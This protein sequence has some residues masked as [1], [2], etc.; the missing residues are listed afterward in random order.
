M[1]ATK[2]ISAYIVDDEKD[3]RE[4]LSKMIEAYLPD[5]LKVIGTA[6]M[7]EKALKEIAEW[8]PQMLFL[9]IEIPRMTGLELAQNLHDKGYHGK[10]VF[11]TGHEEYMLKAIRTGA[12]DYLL[13]PVNPDEL[14]N[15]V[16]RYKQEVIEPFNQKLIRQWE[17]SDREVKLVSLLSEGL[18]SSEIG[19][20]MALS[21]HTVD[22][23][24]RRI[25]RKTGCRN[26]I[27]LLNLLRR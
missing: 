4:F 27:E 14:Q 20:K 17:L 6:E 12:Y 5:T 21:R 23:H 3:G 1:T 2:T 25:L 15:V 24:R 26:P 18:T 10:I 13:K 11:V 7:P 22:T 16:K 9:D 19:E 8:Q